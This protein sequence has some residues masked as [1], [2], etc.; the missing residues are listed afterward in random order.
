MC[1]CPDSEIISRQSSLCRHVNTWGSF[2]NTSQKKGRKCIKETERHHKERNR[3]EWGQKEE[4]N[5]MHPPST[6]SFITKDCC[7][8]DTPAPYD[9]HCCCLTQMPL[10]KIKI[11]GK[12][13][14]PSSN[15]RH[16]AQTFIS[17]QNPKHT[18]YCFKIIQKIVLN[19]PD[20]SS[21]PNSYKKET[22]I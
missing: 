16:C 4:F 18:D 19:A 2:Q 3:G 12:Y 8:H 13:I 17:D 21:L 7:I 9:S 5:N 14:L 11:F 20:H 15:E 1:H 6:L 22:S 10:Y